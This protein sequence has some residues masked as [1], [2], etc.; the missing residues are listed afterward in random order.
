MNTEKSYEWRRQLLWG[1][2]LIGVGVAIFLDRL[3]LFEVDAVWH[4]W[5]LILVVIGINKMIGFPTAR[6][7]SSGLWLV[8]LGVWLFANFENMFG[9]TFYTSWPILIIAWGMTL[10]IEPFIQRRF[11]SNQEIRDEK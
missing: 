10:V 4:Y 11:P 5:P 3:D 7:F 9:L 2:L 1:L 6:H 8:F